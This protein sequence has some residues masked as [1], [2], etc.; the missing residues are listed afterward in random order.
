MIL[1]RLEGKYAIKSKTIPWAHQVRAYTYLHTHEAT[2]LAMKMGTGKSKVFVDYTVNEGAK[3]VLILCPNNVADVWVEQYYT[4]ADESKK[5]T[6]VPLGRG[7]GTVVEKMRLARK[8][9][10]V[11]WPLVVVIV[12]FESAWREPLASLLL[13]THWDV[14]GIDESHRIKQ[15]GAKI[16]RFCA[17]L[18]K[19]GK[20][21][22][23]MSGTPMAHS[24][25]DVY[26]QYRFLDPSIFGSNYR[27][28]QRRYALLGG[29]T[30]TWVKGYQNEKEL[31]EKFHRIALVV[32]DDVLDLP[33]TVTVKRRFD[34]EAKTRKIYQALEREFYAEVDRGEV[35]VTNALTKLLR[36]QQVTSGY[37]PLDSGELTKLGG[38]KQQELFEVLYDLA[39]EEKV[40]IFA[41]FRADLEAIHAV[42]DRLGR[43]Y[44]ELSGRA[45]E[46]DIWKERG[47]ILGCQIQS[48]SQGLSMVEARYCIYYSLGFS[49]VDYDQS[50]KRVHRPGQ[51]RSTTFIYLLAAGTVDEK[52]LASLAKRGNVID[53]IINGRV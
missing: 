51:K 13:K 6:L 43:T 30:N 27:L 53:D 9:L 24:P 18:A 2:M 39:P 34:L 45:R 32:G 26:G 14:I 15:P 8:A 3:R 25:L 4:H 1:K 28:F 20:K 31:Y 10:E 41:K 35:T 7:T 47:A 46:L 16:S 22:V 50:L 29:P 21:R 33:P 12:N 48:G 17:R 44:H 23:C 42:A 19:Q 49:L 36:L 38:E 40:V 37:L 52:V 11:D 5:V